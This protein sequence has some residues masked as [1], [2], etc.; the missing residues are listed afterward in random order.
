MGS[1]S[2]RGAGGGQLCLPC[3]SGGTHV[4]LG[5]GGGADLEKSPGAGRELQTLAVGFCP[6]VGFCHGVPP[7]NA[8]CPHPQLCL[9][10]MGTV[11]MGSDSRSL[12]LVLI[13]VGMC[14]LL[15][16]CTQTLSV[17]PMPQLRFGPKA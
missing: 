11:A 8:L 9:S 10:L 12:T 3:R 17:L 4:G 1:T 15:G 13:E 7:V 16:L 5:G 6:Q 14:L 2:A